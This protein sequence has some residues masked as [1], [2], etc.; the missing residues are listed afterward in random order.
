MAK[1][2]IALDPEYPFPYTLLGWTHYMDVWYRTSKSPKQSISRAFELAQKALSL[3]ASQVMAH[4]LLAY[5]YTAKRQYEKAIEE[6]EQSLAINPNYADG[7]CHKARSLHYVRRNEESIE[8][9]RKAIRLNPFPPSYYY[10]QLGYCYFMTEQYDQAVAEF[11]KAIK[12]QPD[13][14]PAFVGLATVYGFSD[15]KKEALLAGKEVVRIQPEF[16][17]QGWVKRLPYKN[18]TDSERLRSGLYKAG[19]PE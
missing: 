8:L 13:N 5:I 3:D 2:A 19:L 18:E 15:K 11:K 16:S 6:V 4:G 12:L 7:H 10:Y 9:I 1:D 14:L 17:V